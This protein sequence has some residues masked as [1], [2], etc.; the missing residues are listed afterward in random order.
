MNSF[1]NVNPALHPKNLKQVQ[2]V[3]EFAQNNNAELYLVGGYLRDLFCGLIK[4]KTE[5]KDLD[6]TVIK[7]PA[8]EFA[9]Q[10]ANHVQ[11]H[12]VTLDDVSDT[13]RVVLDDGS[14]IDFAHCLNDDLKADIMRRDFT[15]NALAYNIDRPEEIIDLSGGLKD[16][17]TRTIRA[18]SKENLE[19]DP[20][21]LLR[22]FRFAATIDGN[23]EVETLSW[24]KELNSCLMS[25]AV[26]RINHEL[27]SFFE[28]RHTYRHLQTMSECGILE[29][30]FPELETT[31]KV[32]T[33]AFHHLGLFDHSLELVKQS[34]IHIDQLPQWSKDDLK[35]EVAQSISRL[36]ACKLACLLHDIGKPDTWQIQEDGKHTFIGH[37]RVG[38]EMVSSIAKR[39]KWSRPLSKYIYD[40]VLYHLRPGA[41][42]HQ[43]EPTDKAVH[44][45]YR[46]LS[47]IVNPLILLALCD[48]ASTCGSGFD[49][50]R[51]DKQKTS[52]FELL[53]NF[54]VFISG[55]EKLQRLIDGNDV[56]E[57]L[58]IKRGKLIGEIL[59]IVS[60]AQ[61]FG[62]IQSREEACQLVKTCYEQ[63]LLGKLD[64]DAILSNLI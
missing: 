63:Y 24:I 23:I 61:S 49:Q 35:L 13:A 46:K 43:Q 32:T 57:I 11:G 53:S 16:L 48:L 38:A 39:M 37:D 26:E 2:T 8:M 5:I 40:L 59:E 64:P 6:F 52:L 7:T 58:S 17:S 62:K 12:F 21:R 22:A 50:E 47:P 14:Y 54:L 42:F 15:I 56:M 18:I 28:K 1:G 45:F 36:S 9:K 30:I 25:A 60:E 34:E 41:L 4:D 33:N 55:E 51:R 27:F 20:L 31:K 29:L 3:F 10:F 44:R 19:E